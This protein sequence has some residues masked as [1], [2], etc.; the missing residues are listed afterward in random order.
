ML[1]RCA[2]PALQAAED[3]E[4]SQASSDLAYR[5]P[6]AA[7]GSYLGSFSEFPADLECFDCPEGAMCSGSMAHEVV[8]LAGYQWFP[9]G[10]GA[11]GFVECEGTDAVSRCDGWTRADSARVVAGEATLEDQLGQ[12]RA[13]IGLSASIPVKW[14]DF[15]A[16]V[17][18]QA[19]THE[20]VV[21]SLSAAARR[22][23]AVSN[24]TESGIESRHEA[25]QEAA[26]R[27]EVDVQGIVG[28]TAEA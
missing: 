15:V 17:A 28:S 1:P 12:V 16:D 10:E 23:Q 11:L 4:A 22:A 13:R 6:A 2:L 9:G 27:P 18:R 14:S 5:G 19:L 8:P 20:S 21:A 24:G 7:F 3:A 26:V 25:L